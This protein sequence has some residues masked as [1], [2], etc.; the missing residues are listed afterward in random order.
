[1]KDSEGMESLG[2][3]FSIGVRVLQ[4]KVT[5]CQEIVVMSEV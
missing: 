5:I 3:A 4:L 1:M 2:K